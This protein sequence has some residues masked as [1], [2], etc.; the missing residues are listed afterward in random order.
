MLLP[1]LFE[2]MKII[3]ASRANSSFEAIE[4]SHNEPIHPNVRL[5]VCHQ[6]FG[7]VYLISTRNMEAFEEIFY[8]YRS[9]YLYPNNVLDEGA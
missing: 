9:L 6:H 1:Q 2:P 7:V 3:S 8:E 5:F 4:D